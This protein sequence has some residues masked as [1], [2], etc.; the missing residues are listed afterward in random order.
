MRFCKTVIMLL[1]LALPIMGA[2]EIDAFRGFKRLR[3]QTDISSVSVITPQGTPTNFQSMNGKWILMNIWA[4]WCAPCIAELP[5]LNDLAMRKPLADLDVI[6]VSFD[7]NKS[8]A[9][10]KAFLVQHNIADFASYMDDNFKLSMALKSQGLPMTYL[11][12]PQGRIVA[13]YRGG[14]NWN[15]P[16]VVQA[17][18]F[19][20]NSGMTSNTSA[21]KP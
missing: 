14:A 16:K 17:L 7:S 9:D 3:T 10:V 18:S 2:S 20:V 1:C 6:A 11:V 4:T 12:N 19:F 21:T 15:D 5:M 13:E 8:Q